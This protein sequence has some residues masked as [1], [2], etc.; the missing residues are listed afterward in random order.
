VRVE[1]GKGEAVDSSNLSS[2][3]FGQALY[4]SQGVDSAFR[5]WGVDIEAKDKDYW[6]PLHSAAYNGYVEVVKLLLDQGADIEAKST[7]T[8]HPFIVQP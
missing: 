3:T 6:T 8:R 7:S 5:D 1:D 2:A 4:P